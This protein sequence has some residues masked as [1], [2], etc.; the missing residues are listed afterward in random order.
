MHIHYPSVTLNGPALH[1]YHT[2][3]PTADGLQVTFDSDMSDNN[4]RLASQTKQLV[5]KRKSAHITQWSWGRLPN[6]LHMTDT[7]LELQ[8]LALSSF[9]VWVTSHGFVQLSEKVFP[10]CSL[11]NIR[12]SQVP[13]K[14]SSTCQL[15]AGGWRKD[16]IK[17]LL[18]VWRSEDSRTGLLH[19]HP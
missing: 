2:H 1:Q 3:T 11:S 12:H 9:R 8:P 14:H 7:R 4:D 18:A 6:S 17:T 13:L 10:S 16:H 19:F 5:I 15:T